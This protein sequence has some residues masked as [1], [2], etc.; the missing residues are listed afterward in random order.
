MPSSTALVFGCAQCPARF[1][2]LKRLLEHVDEKH[3]TTTK[4]E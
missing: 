2:H 1:P 3:V 4:E